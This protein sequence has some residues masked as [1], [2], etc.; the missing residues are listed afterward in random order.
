MRL[1][2]TPGEGPR[3]AAAPVPPSGSSEGLLDPLA[4]HSPR[5]SFGPGS[6]D[7]RQKAREKLRKILD[8]RDG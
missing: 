7:Y 6:G 5:P 8:G 4:E 1:R 2:S 3:A